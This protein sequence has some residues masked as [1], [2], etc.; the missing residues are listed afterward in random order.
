MNK[1]KIDFVTLSRSDY[2]SLKPIIDSCKKD[3]SFETGVIAG[4]SHLLNRYGYSIEQVKKD[5]DINY[6]IDFLAENDDTEI[7]LAQSHAKAVSRFVEIFSRRQP[8]VIFILG[9]RWE[10]L[11]VAT[12]ASILRIPIA[13][14]S[15]GDITLGAYDNQV[16]YA[17]SNLSHLHYVA[18][19][20]HATRLCHM[21]EEP[22]RV[23]ITGEPAL[24]HLSSY[25]NKI[26][27]LYKYLNLPENKDFV[28]ST[29]HT[30]TYEK[31][32]Y[33][34]QIKKFLLALD[35]IK[36]PV[37]ITAP[38]PD[39]NSKPLYEVLKKYAD[40]NKNII[41]RENLGADLYY[42]AMS[43]AKFMIGN[44]SSGVWEAPSFKLPVVNIGCRQDGKVKSN[45]VIDVN[46][47]LA[48]IKKAIDLASSVSFKDSI[49]DSNPYVCENSLNIILDNLKS[50]PTKEVLL[51]KKF[52]DP[53][54]NK[55]NNI[56]K[57]TREEY[58]N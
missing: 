28:L 31:L 49:S 24:L 8:D 3:E 54:Y 4:G 26:N 16:R 7:E 17:V 35:L 36:L 32:N 53:I 58:A 29:F 30:V 56:T 41:F 14:H 47:E 1:T 21:G 39:E 9:D 12:A 51:N 52:K 19:R 23:V 45:N 6:I 33:S 34:E 18:L 42:A 22:W 57:L 5:F 38:N 27:N 11:S 20:D 50:I 44:S 10:L 55:S 25:K 37:V 13:H 43:K 2:S 15:G 46:F 48:E 40:N